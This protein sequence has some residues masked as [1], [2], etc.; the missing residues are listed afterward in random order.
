MVH[1]SIYR[2]TP[3]GGLE[4]HPQSHTVMVQQNMP[5]Y[6]KSGTDQDSMVDNVMV[7]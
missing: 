4:H 7:L 3:H 6:R 1:I 2:L 5:V